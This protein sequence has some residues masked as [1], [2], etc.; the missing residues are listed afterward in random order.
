MWPPRGVAALPGTRGRERAAPRAP[1]SYPGGRGVGWKR[2]SPPCRAQPGCRAGCGGPGAVGR[3]LAG[4]AEQR[5][6]W[7]FAA[8]GRERSERSAREASSAEHLQRCP[9]AAAQPS[10][11][12]TPVLASRLGPGVQGGGLAAGSRAVLRGGAAG[13]ELS[14][15][16]PT[17]KPS[18]VRA[19]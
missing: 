13:A 17:P 11:S 10:P 2:R 14:E 7:C 8:E 1:F 5:S 15:L 16:T 12:S 4:R 19:N 6:T 3:R 18:C 9:E